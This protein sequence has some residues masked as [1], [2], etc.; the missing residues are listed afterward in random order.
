MS[1]VRY[2]YRSSRVQVLGKDVGLHSFKAA[3]HVL[4]LSAAEIP[5]KCFFHLSIS[6]VLRQC[7]ITSLRTEYAWF[8]VYCII[9]IMPAKKSRFYAIAS[10]S[11]VHFLS[12]GPYR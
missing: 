11:N 2:I 5:S 6:R 3:D 1:L 12:A 8:A 10:E 4:G 7:R 9:V